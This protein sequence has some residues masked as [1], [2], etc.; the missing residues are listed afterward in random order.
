[1]STNSSG[2]SS[3]VTYVFPDPPFSPSVNR[4]LLDAPEVYLMQVQSGLPPCSLKKVFTTMISIGSRNTV[5]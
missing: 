5:H 2:F 1:M 4:F 3:S